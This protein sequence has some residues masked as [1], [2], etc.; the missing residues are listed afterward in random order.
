[1]VSH[2]KKK[3]KENQNTTDI[4]SIV[5]PDH[6]KEYTCHNIVLDAERAQSDANELWLFQFPPE[7]CF[8]NYICM[9]YIC[10]IYISHRQK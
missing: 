6:L 8:T 5:V 9:Y 4:A 1:M 3:Q 10:T 7:V 2:T